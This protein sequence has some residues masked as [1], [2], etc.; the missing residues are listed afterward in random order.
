MIRTLESQLSRP[1]VERSQGG[2]GGGSSRLTDAG[3]TLLAR[4]EQYTA[5]VRESA[6]A[7]FREHFGGILE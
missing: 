6:E 4:Y 7:L 5:A 3:R 1:L 2:S